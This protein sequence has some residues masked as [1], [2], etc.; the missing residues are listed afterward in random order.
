MGVPSRITISHGLSSVIENFLFGVIWFIFIHVVDAFFV[1]FPCRRVIN[2]QVAASD[3]FLHAPESTERLEVELCSTSLQT[4][5]P[6][7]SQHNIT[8]VFLVITIPVLLGV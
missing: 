4:P 7:N 6:H 5:D 3:S 1:F 2:I 8:S